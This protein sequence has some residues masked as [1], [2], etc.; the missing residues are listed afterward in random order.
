MTTFTPAVPVASPQNPG[1]GSALDRVRLAPLMGRTAG[2]PEVTIGVIDGPVD[3]EHPDLEQRSIRALAGRP[4]SCSGEDVACIHGTFVAGI[5][6]ARRGTAAPAICPACTLAL[7]PI[8]GASRTRG[9]PSATP[10][11]L[12]A[13]IRECI[14]SGARIVNVSAALTSTRGDEQGVL[15]Q[16]LDLAVRRG[17]LVVVAAGNQATLASSILTRHPWALP[18]VACAVSGRPVASAT[19]SRSTGTHGLC[20]P[21]DVISLA[22][23][24]GRRRLVGSSAAAPF[25]TGA[26]ALIWSQYPGAHVSEIRLALTGGGRRS[27]VVPPLLDAWSAYCELTRKRGDSR[28]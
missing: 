10:P 12:A 7:R 9:V 27:S 23:G 18:V 13:A 6:A 11:E 21:G 14:E 15:A 22:P 16:A 1:D 25:V 24:G 5:L 28:A 4:P 3:L 17:A 2:R 26:A 20:A 19:L 8:F